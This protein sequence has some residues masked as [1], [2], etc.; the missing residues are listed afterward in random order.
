MASR[1]SSKA[2]S[3]Q[4]PFCSPVSAALC[5]PPCVHRPVSTIL[6]LP[7]CVRRPVS[8]TLCPPSCV[9]RPVSAALWS[10]KQLAL[11]PS[12][13][14]PK[15]QITA[16]VKTRCRLLT[17]WLLGVAPKGKYDIMLVPL[18]NASHLPPHYCKGDLGIYRL[19]AS[20]PELRGSV[21]E[22]DEERWTGASAFR[23]PGVPPRLS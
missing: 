18:I 16:Q 12:C 14:S 6:C 5:S 2:Q 8:T 1:L 23:S 11:Q 22:E 21:P 7:P 20:P 19:V 10:G 9:Y 3:L 4:L 13:T 17:G 15:Q